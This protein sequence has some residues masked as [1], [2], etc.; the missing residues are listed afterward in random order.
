MSRAITAAKA[1]KQAIE[2]LLRQGESAEVA[3]L[4]DQWFEAP[5]NTP[6]APATTSPEG[7][8]TPNTD[9]PA[10]TAG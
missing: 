4:G 10:V 6:E 3:G 1:D 9:T 2:L 8:V 5:V 7:A